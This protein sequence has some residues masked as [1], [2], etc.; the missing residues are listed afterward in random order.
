[1]SLLSGSIIEQLSP[2]IV[3]KEIK[4]KLLEL[5]KRLI[6]CLIDLDIDYWLD[7]GSLLGL[8]RH[9]GIIPW[10]EDI[11]IGISV[12]D[13]Y[14][15]LDNI[16]IF[17]SYNISIKKNRTGAYFQADNNISTPF[18]LDKLIH[19]DIFL[20][21]IKEDCL[22]NTDYRFRQPD[23][24]SGHC[25]MTYKKK[26]LFPTKEYLYNGIT[27]KAP[28]NIKN[29]L[30]FNLGHDYMNIARIKKNNSIIFSIDLLKLDLASMN[31]LNLT[32]H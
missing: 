9:S 26:D 30:D 13:S 32:N 27:V 18:I 31:L 8:Y 19:I 6:K 14:K 20:Y 29:V 24:L 16:D 22:Y 28:C 10:D 12:L 23:I 3:D 11:D 1:M 2:Y 17:R 5:F 15:I 7:G 4:K 21:E 25:N